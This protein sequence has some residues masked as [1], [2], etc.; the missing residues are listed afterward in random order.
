MTGTLWIL[1]ANA[2][3]AVLWDN[4]DLSEEARLA[5][6][7]AT[8]ESGSAQAELRMPLLQKSKLLWIISITS[9]EILELTSH[10]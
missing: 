5:I 4:I 3:K 7:R 6:V 1:S 2:S 9:N 10:V 8:M